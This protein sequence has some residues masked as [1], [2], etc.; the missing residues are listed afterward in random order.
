MPIVIGDD[1]PGFWNAKGLSY[2][3]YYAIMSLAPNNGGLK[4]LKTLVWNSVR[5]STLKGEKQARAFEILELSWSRFIDEVL[6]G[7]IFY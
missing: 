7:S 1:D 6:N 5:Y 4:I 3:L 2:D